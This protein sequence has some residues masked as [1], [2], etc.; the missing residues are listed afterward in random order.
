MIFRTSPRG[1]LWSRTW[2]LSFESKSKEERGKRELRRLHKRNEDAHAAT[3]HLEE[4]SFIQSYFSKIFPIDCFLNF[5]PFE[6][7]FFL[8][9]RAF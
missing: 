2:D 9:L 1:H 6:I 5:F 7:F 8:T 4:S 3:W